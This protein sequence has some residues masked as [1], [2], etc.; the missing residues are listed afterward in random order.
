MRVI[1]FCHKKIGY[2]LIYNLY[3]NKLKK[4][5]IKKLAL[6]FKL[7]KKLASVILMPI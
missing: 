5:A 2:K 7:V 3:V 6:Q 4:I 1:S